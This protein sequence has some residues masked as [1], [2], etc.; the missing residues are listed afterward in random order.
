MVLMRI[1]QQME[2]GKTNQEF[3]GMDAE[4]LI[5][6]KTGFQDVEEVRKQILLDAEKARKLEN[7]ESRAARMR[8]AKL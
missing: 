5:R 3:T 7:D 8:Q 2:A 1:N 6:A 4:D